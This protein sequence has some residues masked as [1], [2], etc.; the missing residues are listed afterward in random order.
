MIGKKI[1]TVEIKFVS[2]YTNNVG[3]IEDVAITSS[4]GI[5]ELPTLIGILEMTKTK[6]TINEEF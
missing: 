1:I 2:D 5:V 3:Y 4:T 6:I